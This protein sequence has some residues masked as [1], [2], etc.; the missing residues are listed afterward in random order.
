MLQLRDLRCERGERLLFDQF[1][2]NCAPGDLVEIRGA[3]GCG[4]STLLRIIAGLAQDYE[5]SVTWLEQ[6]VAVPASEFRSRSLY[7]G[8]SS[9][10]KASLTPLENLT[11]L[12]ELSGPVDH[13]RAEAALQTM[14]L[15]ECDGVLCHHLSAGQ[16]RRVALA[17]LLTVDAQ[18]WILDEPF[19]ALDAA[20]VTLLQSLIQQQ[21]EQ[22]GLV[23]LT[24]HQPL[25]GV[26]D[27]KLVQL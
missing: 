12:S 21:A 22:G 23:I 9:A 6:G 14:Q 11:W 20:G 25:T 17:R 1:N 3:N 18:L 2:V 24:T 26:S 10:V 8:H 7:L 5:G 13:A 15:A 4:K 19:T 27:V 16:Q